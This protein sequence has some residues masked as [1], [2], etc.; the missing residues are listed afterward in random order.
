MNVLQSD[1]FAVTSAATTVVTV[2]DS[3]NYTRVFAF[4]NL[5]VDRT[6]ALIIEHSADGGANWAVAQASFNL[7]AGEKAVVTIANTYSSILRV[8]ASGGE[9]ARDLML[10]YFRVK[11]SSDVWSN[12]TS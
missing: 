8:R 6:L 4:E 5:T 12:P 11:G 2:R 3:N 9:G 10:S 7:A 1:V